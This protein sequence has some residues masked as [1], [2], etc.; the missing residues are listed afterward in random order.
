[1]F[2]FVAA[3][4]CGFTLCFFLLVCLVLHL[5]FLHFYLPYFVQFVF[6]IV[7]FFGSALFGC[8]GFAYFGLFGF[9]CYSSFFYCSHV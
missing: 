2:V 3:A 8:F 6:S 5:C 9:A 1:M 7:W 4:I